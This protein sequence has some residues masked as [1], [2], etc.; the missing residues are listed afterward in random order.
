MKTYILILLTLISINLTGQPLSELKNI[1]TEEEAKS[2]I[3]KYPKLKPELIYLNSIHD[4]LSFSKKLLTKKRGGIYK[5]DKYIYKIL[6]DTISYNFRAS[7]IY[8]D[9]SKLSLIEIDSIKELILS[10]YKNGKSFIELFKQYNMD[11]NTSFGDTE[12]YGEG[13]VAKEFEDAVR[14]H[15]VGDIFKVDV[16]SRNWYYVVKKTFENQAVK[17]I[18]VLKTKSSS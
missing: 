8:L 18:T 14:K 17:E 16:P 6:S 5:V 15:K 2:F 10:E 11:T 1:R 12:F 4:T 3:N 13:V 9:G 7:Y